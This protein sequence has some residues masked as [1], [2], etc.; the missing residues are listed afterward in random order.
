METMLR[1][2]KVKMMSKGDPAILQNVFEKFDAKNQ[3]QL[4]VGNFKTC[5]MQADLGFNMEDITRLAR[6]LEKEGN[7]NINYAKFLKLVDDVFFDKHKLDDL[8]KFASQISQYLKSSHLT[9][10]KF[11]KDIQESGGGE[12]RCGCFEQ[13]IFFPRERE[14]EKEKIRG[15]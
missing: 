3:G 5:F 13:M 8:G 15:D 6:Y 10:L 9:Y 7:G 14:R 2:V 1:R 4:S 11:I 12:Y